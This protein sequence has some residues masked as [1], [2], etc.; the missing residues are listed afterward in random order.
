MS[1]IT[2]HALI[3]GHPNA[4]SFTQSAAR[5]YQQSV[6]ALG[7]TVLVRDLYG[8]NFDPRL[9]FEEIP[10]QTGF[11]PGDDIVAE[12]ALIADANVFTFFYPLWFNVPPA[13]ITGY[14]QR[15]LSMGFGYGPVRNGANQRL[16]LG[17]SML[18]FSSSGAP[19]EWLR[20]EGGWDALTNLFDD[21]VAEVCGMSVLD[22]RHF[23]RVLNATPACRIDA[24]FKE[25]RDTVAKH[26][27]SANAR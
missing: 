11:A 13:I 16:L 7:H 10:R 26:F 9:Q 8:M 18:S 23:G 6:E 25:V 4:D 3:V 22:H 5:V 1:R 24:H 21:H 2:K 17:R 27:G 14:V 15:V 20:S 12:R 19:A